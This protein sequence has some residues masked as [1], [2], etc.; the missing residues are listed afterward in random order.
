METFLKQDT[1][2]KGEEAMVLTRAQKRKQDFQNSSDEKK[3][4]LSGAE[5]HKILTENGSDTIWPFDDSIFIG[6]CVKQKKSRKQRREEHARH[7]LGLEAVT[8]NLK[9]NDLVKLVK[10]DES[11]SKVRSTCMAAGKTSIVVEGLY[12]ENGL[13]HCKWLPPGRTG[14]MVIDQLVLPSQCRKQVLELA[15][16]VPLAGHLG[17]KKTE[18]RIHVLQRFYWPGVHRDVANYCKQCAKCLRSSMEGRTRAPFL[19]LE[20][21]L[22]E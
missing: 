1:C 15:H 16:S 7:R 9:D 8:T 14:D 12:E 21:L 18:Q 20:N 5:S 10:E 22:H 4:R 13:V 17:R 6:G 19:S 2:E 11:L 3:D